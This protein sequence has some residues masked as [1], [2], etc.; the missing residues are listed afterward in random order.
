MWLILFFT[1]GW[2]L[3]WGVVPNGKISYS[4]DFEQESGFVKKITPAERTE[5]IINGQQK[6]IGDPVY[7]SLQT[8]RR[9]DKAKMIL[10]YR[11]GADRNEDEPALIEIGV[12]ADAKIWRYQ[13][14]PIQNNIID[15][16]AL[17]WDVEKKYDVL[18]LQKE[19]KYQSVDDFLN[20]I[21]VGLDRDERQ[22]VALYN[23][24]LKS[25][26]LIDD[27]QAS[28]QYQEIFTF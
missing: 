4:Y 20:K 6:I 10:E 23:Y 9:F 14:Q 1:I 3:Y 22:A 11:T 13:L 18:F 7:F 8:P 25:K 28:R 26:Y 12:L 24:D 2:F 15:Q 17:V 19:K 21:S 27:Y 5:S 16:L